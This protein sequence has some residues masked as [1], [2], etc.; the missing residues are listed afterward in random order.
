MLE[1]YNETIRDLLLMKS[2]EVG[3]KKYNISHDSNGNT[4]VSDLLKRAAQSRYI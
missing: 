4:N 1:I 3:G 2:S